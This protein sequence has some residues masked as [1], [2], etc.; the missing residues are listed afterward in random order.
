VGI[1][2]VAW[3]LI[4]GLQAQIRAADLGPLKV[5]WF[6]LVDTLRYALNAARLKS[7]SWGASRRVSAYAGALVGAGRPKACGLTG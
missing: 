7:A 2:P 5:G 4:A 1:A 6:I 3:R